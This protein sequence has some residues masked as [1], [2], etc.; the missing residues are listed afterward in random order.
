VKD[1][2][3]VNGY[4]NAWRLNKTGSYDMTIKF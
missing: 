1:R 2:F 4:A 3:N